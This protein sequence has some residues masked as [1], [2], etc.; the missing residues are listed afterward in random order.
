MYICFYLCLYT[1]TEASIHLWQKTL[2]SH[3]WPSCSC[4]WEITHTLFI[5]HLTW[6]MVLFHVPS[7]PLASLSFLCSVILL[8]PVLSR[9]SRV[10]MVF[11]LFNVKVSQFYLMDPFPVCATLF[12]NCVMNSMASFA[13]SVMKISKCIY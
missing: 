6:Y 11:D 5:S 4:I 9:N 1:A 3:Q 2:R 12:L 13:I 7:L 10:F 8:F